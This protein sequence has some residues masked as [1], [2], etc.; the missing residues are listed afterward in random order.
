[1]FINSVLLINKYDK[2]EKLIKYTIFQIRDK[3]IV[4]D[5]KCWYIYISLSLFGRLPRFL[6]SEPQTVQEPR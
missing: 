4:L 5:F 2:F 1:M 6:L 3:I